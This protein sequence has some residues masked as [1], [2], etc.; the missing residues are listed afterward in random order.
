VALKFAASQ[1]NIDAVVTLIE[2][3]AHPTSKSSCK[4]YGMG[5]TPFGKAC[6]EGH[7]KIVNL[8]LE[9]RH[10]VRRKGPKY[11]Q[12]VLN[13]ARG[14]RDGNH[15]HVEILKS[16]LAKGE[17]SNL[18]KLQCD[19]I[20]EACFWGREDVLRMV[21]EDF[22][23]VR[24]LWRGWQ[25]ALDVAIARKRETIVQILLAH[26]AARASEISSGKRL[27]QGQQDD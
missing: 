14:R 11:D 17:F 18:R 19:I 9:P 21:L 23:S 1:G 7:Q 2:A 13:A 4:G 3:G 10:G 12:A 16:L 20:D 8:F 15:G 27:V 24:F 26:G 25:T 5:V 22:P 6:E